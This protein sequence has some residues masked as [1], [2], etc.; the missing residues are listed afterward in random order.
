MADDFYYYRKGYVMKERLK[1]EEG[2]T[3]IEIIVVLSILLILLMIVTVNIAEYTDNKRAMVAKSEAQN[4][5][6]VTNGYTKANSTYYLNDIEKLLHTVVEGYT[7]DSTDKRYYEI[8]TSPKLMIYL[9]YELDAELGLISEIDPYAN[10]IETYSRP[11]SNT[12]RVEE[13]IR[14]GVVDR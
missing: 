12:D 1:M 11:G 6:E 14:N 13:L 3:L 2:F 10:S 8:V 7:V 5:L 9:Y 4:V